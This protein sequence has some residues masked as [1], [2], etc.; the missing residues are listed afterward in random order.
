MTVTEKGFAWGFKDAQ[1][2]I[3]VRYTMT[4]T[5]KGE[6]HETGQYTQDG[7][8]WSQ[9]IEMTLTRVKE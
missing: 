1:S 5:P 8:N 9:F 7:K 2:G 3:E 6:W 4:F